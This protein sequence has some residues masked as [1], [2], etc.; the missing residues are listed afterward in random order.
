MRY[1]PETDYKKQQL[2]GYLKGLIQTSGNNTVTNACKMVCTTCYSYV[3]ICIL[4]YC[5]LF[6]YHTGKPA[7]ILRAVICR[8]RQIGF[9]EIDIFS[10]IS[11]VQQ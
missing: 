5:Y 1:D 3:P 10:S 9:C 7:A 8:K 4:A 6:D 11:T 2:S